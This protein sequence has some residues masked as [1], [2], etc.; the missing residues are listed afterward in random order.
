MGLGD[1]ER[2][3]PGEYPSNLISETR[4]IPEGER[5]S[6]YQERPK[7]TEKVSLTAGYRLFGGTDSPRV[8]PGVEEGDIRYAF[9]GAHGICAFHSLP[10]QTAVASGP[11]PEGAAD[12]LGPVAATWRLPQ[13][14]CLAK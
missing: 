12:S 2:E 14:D 1:G 9:S 10:G 13:L 4:P 7:D 11:S 5:N 8:Y 3:E 6:V